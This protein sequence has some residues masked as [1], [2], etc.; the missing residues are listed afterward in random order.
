MHAIERFLNQLG[1][2]SSSL[3]TYPSITTTEYKAWVDNNVSVNE[4]PLKV[5]TILCSL[6]HLSYDDVLKQLI[7]YELLS[8]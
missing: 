5:F 8:E 4:L 6:S 2:D 7:K 1:K 3:L